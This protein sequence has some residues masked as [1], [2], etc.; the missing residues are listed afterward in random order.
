MLARGASPSRFFHTF[1]LSQVY[2]SG[3]GYLQR[4]AELM[5]DLERKPP[6]ALVIDPSTARNDPDGSRGLNLTSFPELER[7]V[8]QRYQK[9]ENI[10][11]TGGWVAYELRS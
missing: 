2:A 6:S 10:G 5:R 1:P 3:T 11:L 8:E 9:L 4:R 7:F